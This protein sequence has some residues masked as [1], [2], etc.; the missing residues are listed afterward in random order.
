MKDESDF[1]NARRGKLARRDA[2]LVPPQ[3][4]TARLFMDRGSQCVLLPDEFR[5]EGTEMRVS[6]YGKR[7]IL[8]PIK[9][10]RAPKN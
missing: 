6:R 1:S 8:S 10:K 9:K 7:V 2:R 3:T 4:T 5:L